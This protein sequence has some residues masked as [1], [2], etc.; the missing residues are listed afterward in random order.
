MHG[1]TP[2]PLLA[3]RPLPTILRLAGPTTA[4]MFAQSGVSIAEMYVVGRLGTPALA[5]FQLVFPFLMLMTMMA[6]GGIGGGIASAV[7]RALGAGDRPRA[8][9]LA[10]HAL[11][12]AAGFA[13]MWTAAMSL[14]GPALFRA[15]GARDAT[16][17]NAV[18]YATVLFAGA[19]APWAMFALSS[20]LRGSGDAATPGKFM[21]LASLLQIPL[22]GLL[23]LGTAGWG[24][25]DWPGLGIAGAAVSSIATSLL[26]SAL[27]ARRLW[28]GNTGFTPS[29]AGRGLAG[30][31]FAA[32]LKVGLIASMSALFANLTTMLVNF[33]IKPFGDAAIAGYGIGAR[34]EF[35]LVPLSF[36][37]GSALTT[38]V[39]IAAGAGAWPRARHVAWTG[40]LMAAALTGTLGI[41]AALFPLGW[42]GLFSRDPAV[43]EAATH[44]LTRAAPFYAFFGLGMSLNFA[45]Q[46]A[47]RMRVPFSASLLR[48]L[49]AGL[50]GY[51]TVTVWHGG[52]PD[53]FWLVG[54]AIMLYGTII[55]GALALRPW[56]GQ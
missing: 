52:L 16:L 51:L 54:L 33:A 49:I 43:L 1:G 25:G 8:A 42:A 26:A 53:L 29:L 55:G 18:A 17:D 48:T 40:G 35:I 10:L 46:G 34:L 45:A 5:G 9:S 20:I 36:G 31:A 39:G 2:H 11:L 15:F 14:A 32:I 37:I 22:S 27:M 3:A 56:H 41:A 4:V 6:A 21:L 28:S 44:Y 24:L 7:A 38:L 12:I 23:V 50:G 47:G 30:T 19:A 13:L